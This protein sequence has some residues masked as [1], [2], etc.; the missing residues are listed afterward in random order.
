MKIIFS[1][2]LASAGLLSG[3]ALYVPDAPGTIIVPQGAPQ[4]GPG[5][6]FC[7]PGQAKKGNC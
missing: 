6:G 1:L 7:P 4:G 2:L 5:N 3:C